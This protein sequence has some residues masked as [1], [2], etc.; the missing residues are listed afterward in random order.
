MPECSPF[1]LITCD[2]NRL[3]ISALSLWCEELPPKK[4]FLRDQSHW[5]LKIL[6]SLSNAFR[7]R[8]CSK[9]ENVNYNNKEKKTQNTSINQETRRSSFHACDDSRAQQ[10]E[11]SP[12]TTQS[13]E[14][15]G[16]C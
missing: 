9:G 7:K 15:H 6:L 10:E 12:G 2:F 13:M 8:S 11:P 3:S 4:F 5:N 1:Y 16:L 14:S